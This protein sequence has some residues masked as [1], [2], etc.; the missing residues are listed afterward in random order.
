MTD[1]LRTRIAA[2]LGPHCDL[3]QSCSCGWRWPADDDREDV[4]QYDLH[5]ADAVIR[6]LQLTVL[7][8]GL[9]VGAIHE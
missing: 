9:V 7:G 4:D 3:G 8:D 5:V 6:E 1:T 2:A